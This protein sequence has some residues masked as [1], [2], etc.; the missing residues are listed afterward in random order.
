LPQGFGSAREV[1]MA[2]VLLD[3][4]RHRHPQS[5]GK[6]LLRHGLLSC[7]IGE[8]PDQAG[9]QVFGTPGTIELNRQF[10]TIRHLTEIGKIRADDRHTVGAGE[11]GNAAAPRRRTV[12]HD[13]DGRTLKK[14]GQ[15]ILV[16]ISGELDAGVSRVLFLDGLDIPG[17]LGMVCSAHHQA[18]RGQD[19][20]D[21]L[22]G[23]D[24]QLEPLVGSPLA[25]RQNAM[26]RVPAPGKIRALG[27]SRQNAMRAEMHVVA[28][29]FF[30]KDFAITG[31]E[32]RH[33]IRQQKHSRS[34]RAGQSVGAGVADSR[35]FQIDGI[36]QMVQGDM[37][38]TAAE[39]RQQGSQQTGKGNQRISAKC[40]E[41]QIE[42]DH[43]RLQ[44]AQ[45][46]QN[47]NRACGIVEGPA[48]YHGKPVQFAQIR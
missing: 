39:P 13:G 40:T 11:V 31:H 23:I 21:Q 12:W 9:G 14:I 10:F 30:V 38:I 5:G 34:H 18:G 20:G 2:H 29:V 17:C 19:L 22:K 45:G 33:R 27:F 3:N 43:I 37:G 42:P 1:K 4:G 44:P 36:H 8:E 25:K 26:L 48:A 46:A 16:D 41:Q 28:A 6:I 15:S 24:H 32:Y 35:V 47:S 7:R